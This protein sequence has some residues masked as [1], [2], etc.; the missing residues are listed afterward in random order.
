MQ[1]PVTLEEVTSAIQ[2][3]KA[4]V[5]SSSQH[6]SQRKVSTWYETQVIAINTCWQTLHIHHRTCDKSWRWT[7]LLPVF[8][9]LNGLGSRLSMTSCALLNLVFNY[10][11]VTLSTLSASNSMT[12][13]YKCYTF[14]RMCDP[15]Y[16]TLSMTLD[17]G[18]WVSD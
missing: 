12:Q 15:G 5:K 2:A 16:Q 8:C 1:Q 6:P 3:F 18:P 7:L 14:T 10:Y 9:H 4:Q 11:K 13:T 17:I